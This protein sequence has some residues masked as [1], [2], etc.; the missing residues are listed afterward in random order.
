MKVFSVSDVNTCTE[1]HVA[2][3]LTLRKRTHNAGNSG[4]RVEEE[5]EEEEENDDDKVKQKEREMSGKH[6]KRREKKKEAYG[7]TFTDKGMKRPLDGGRL[8]TR[9]EEIFCSVEKNFV[10]FCSKASWRWQRMQVC[11]GVSVPGRHP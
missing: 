6:E 9:G 8:Q 11:V 10:F 7:E 1:G 4:N 5:E 3:H 2:T